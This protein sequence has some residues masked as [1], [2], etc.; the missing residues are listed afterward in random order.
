MRIILFMT[1]LLTS[2]FCFSEP[3][4]D[5]LHAFQ[6]ASQ[7][8]PL[9]QQQVA[10]FN[11]VKQEVPKS[12][13]ALLPLIDLSAAIAREFNKPGDVPSNEFF[14][15][16]SYMISA[17]QTVFNYSQ[18]SQLDE[19]RYTVRAAYA[20]LTAQQQD[21]M[22][23]TAR[24]YLEVLRTREILEF[25]E[26]QKAYLETQLEATNGLFELREAT[27][28]DLEQAKGTAYLIDANLYAAQINYYDAIQFLSEITSFQY[29][30]FPYLNPNFPLHAPKPNDV[31]YW[32]DSANKTNWLL[33]SA[34][35]NI[36]ANKKAIDVVRGDYLPNLRAALEIERGD[37]PNQILTD[38]TQ[39]QDYSYGLN[40]RWNTFHGGLTV[41]QEK[42]AR[43][44]LKE[45]EAFM[46]QQYLQTIANTKRAFNTIKVGV[47]RIEAVRK[48]LTANTKALLYAQEAYRAG[49]A[50]ITEILQIQERL[51]ASQRDYAQFT[52]DYLYNI[53]LL[54]QAQGTLSIKDLAQINHYLESKKQIQSV[55][56]NTV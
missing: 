38:T 12:F 22:A 21:L 53:V 55:R 14:S 36:E 47:P 5:L 28:T 46:R 19:S 4:V 27:I 2:G 7:N 1:I 39:N 51:Y 20:T 35:L 33:R 34:R 52:Y 8:D 10:A 54:K 24:A 23:R 25:T 45:S 44:N 17:E 15:T 16:N 13:S 40:A 42:E 3:Q 26:D 32:T 37:V 43:A 9:Y 30:A 18:F 29:K 50:S 48:A 49:E 6:D 11:A 31:D 56:L 41:A